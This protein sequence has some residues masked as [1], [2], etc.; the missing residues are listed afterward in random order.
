[1]EQL[2]FNPKKRNKVRHFNHNYN[3]CSPHKLKPYSL[4]L[5]PTL[6]LDTGMV[7]NIK[8]FIIFN[9]HFIKPFTSL[10]VCLYIY[11][12]YTMISFLIYEEYE[13]YCSSNI[14]LFSISLIC[15]KGLNRLI[16]MTRG[17]IT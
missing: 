11:F 15:V 2:L 6:F 5:D 17:S 16:F 1:M 12:T 3:T 10:L 14:I 4:F 8:N 13:G 9:R 7:K